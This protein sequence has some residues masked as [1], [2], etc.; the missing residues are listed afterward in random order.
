M[1]AAW[2]AALEQVSVLVSSTWYS[3]MGV[4]TERVMVAWYVPRAAAASSF[5][6][7][8]RAEADG[9]AALEVALMVQVVA[10]ASHALAGAELCR[11]RRA[12][13]RLPMA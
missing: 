12:G 7:A 13:A 11:W 3:A 2:Q 8:L 6:A 5:E 9:R 4:A 1:E 10:A